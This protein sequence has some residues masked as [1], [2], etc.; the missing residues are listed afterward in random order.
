MSIIF[1][2]PKGGNGTTVTAAAHALL[3]AHRNVRTVLIDLCGDIPAVLGMP[4]PS[5]P[6]VNE[7]L[8]ESTSTTSSGLMACGVEAEPNLFV[9]P[10]GSR[11]IEGE[12]RWSELSTFVADSP[13]NVVIDAGVTALPDAL[14]KSGAMIATVVRPC[15]LTLRRGV[16]LPRPIN[17]YIVA[18]D[19]RALTVND[20]VHVLGAD[21]HTV[22]PFTSAIARA[23][24]AGLLP[25]R[26][27]QLFGNSL[28]TPSHE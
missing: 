6:G 2:S 22:V 21:H 7:W 19:G 17:A 14:R 18:E 24:D 9:I 26:V 5:G 20:V 28:I 4:E 11:F 13:H 12:P 8:S 16:M 23:V 27:D 1:T 15:Y 25:S 10:R 3:S